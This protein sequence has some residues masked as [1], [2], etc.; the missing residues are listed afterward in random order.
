MQQLL[1]GSHHRPFLACSLVMVSIV[2]IVLLASKL[3]FEHRNCLIASQ[4]EVDS[5]HHQSSGL[6]LVGMQAGR[7]A[8]SAEPPPLAATIHCRLCRRPLPADF[9]SR[10]HP[11]GLVVKPTG[12]AS[13]RNN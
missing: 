4:Q 11:L 6:L 10:K 9:A 1:H 8:D 13:T 2:S 5:N 7:S 3:Y 12:P